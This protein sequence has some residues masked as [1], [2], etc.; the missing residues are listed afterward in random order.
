MAERDLIPAID[1][2]FIVL[3]CEHPAHGR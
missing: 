3:V 1:L 2:I